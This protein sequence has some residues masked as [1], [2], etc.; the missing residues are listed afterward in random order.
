MR[1]GVSPVAAST[2]TGVFSQRFEAFPA[3]E[4]WLVRSVSLPSCSSRFIRSVNVGL[5]ALPA[6]ALLHILSA[7]LP[8]S[9]P[10]TGLDECCFFNSGLWDF[11]IVRFS[12][13]SG[14][15]LFLNL[16]SFFCL[17]EEAQCV[18]LRL[19]LGQKSQATISLRLEDVAVI[20]LMLIQ[21]FVNP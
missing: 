9:A 11:H 14:Y 20:N 2:P 15:F 21:H 18:Y 1:L 4:P 13:S 3:L 8:V 19:H 7:Q 5:P 10:P 16:L 12:G 17:C 6:A